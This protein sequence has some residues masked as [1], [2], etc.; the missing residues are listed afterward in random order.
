[1]LHSLIQ[2]CA[3]LGVR[4]AVA[5]PKGYRPDRTI[6]KAASSMARKSGG[7]LDWTADPRQ[8]ARGADALYTDVWVS[9]GQE[10]ERATR[11]KAFRAYQ[12][13]RALLALAAPR[14]GVMHCL[15]A[16]R[17][18]EITDDVMEGPRSLIVDQA[19]NRLHAHKALLL[20]LFGNKR[21]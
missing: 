15:P 13:N 21:G 14:C 9:M 18:E 5:T 20:L 19:E 1:M 6:W 4:V 7:S 3:M 12:V 17:G 11:L 8:A 2:G 16:H 10:A